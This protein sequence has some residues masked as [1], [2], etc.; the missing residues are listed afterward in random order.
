M[1]KP[2]YAEPLTSERQT[3]AL[4]AG[5]RPLPAAAGASTQSA[6]KDVPVAAAK[7]ALL[8]EESKPVAA[9]GAEQ[10]VTARKELTAPGRLLGLADRGPALQVR[11][12]PEAFDG[13][14][15]PS[16]TLAQ[17]AQRLTVLA[18]ETGVAP[19]WDAAAA[20]WE[21]VIEGVQGGPLESETR[22]QL[23]RARYRA[24]LRGADEKRVARAIEA[25]EAFLARA[26]RGAERDSAQGWMR[27]FER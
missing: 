9:P 13:L 22:F 14:P 23:A 18:E 4:R 15:T 21:R 8:E 12:T 5:A 26:P 17:N 24:W 3:D 2:R 11:G 27:A 20:G 6:D 1:Q 19:A 10:A 7:A 25:L 16:R